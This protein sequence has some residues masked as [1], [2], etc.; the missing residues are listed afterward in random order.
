MKG[1]SVER[2]WFW[3]ASTDSVI[4]A[5]NFPA[6]KV[7]VKLSLN[8]KDEKESGGI[9]PRILNLCTRWGWVVRLTLRP[10]Y[11]QYPLDRGLYASQ[12]RSG[13]TWRGTLASAQPRSLSQC[14]SLHLEILRKIKNKV[15]RPCSWG[16]PHPT[17]LHSPRSR[18]YKS[19]TALIPRVFIMRDV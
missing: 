11:P 3:N 19:N 12:G 8:H 6:D 16:P 5:R 15:S 10:H 14:Q 1:E 9:P 7:Q 13:H 18:T 2:N 4:Y 17:G